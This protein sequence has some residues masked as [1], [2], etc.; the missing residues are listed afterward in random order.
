MKS[1]Q[2]TARKVSTVKEPGYYG[3]GGGLYL[4]VSQY[5]TKSWV[6]RFTLDRKTRD[7]GLGSI[8]TF[9]LKEARERARKYRQLLA[10]G[11]DPIEDRLKKRDEARADASERMLFKDAAQLFLDVHTQ[12][13]RNEKHRQQWRNTLRTYAYPT[14]GSRPVSAIDGAAI[15]EA[16]SPIWL[17]KQET[18]SRTKQRIERVVQWVRDGKPLPHQSAAK[19]VRHHPALPFTEL[20]AFMAELREN[21]SISARA[22]EFTILTAART[23]ETI[24]AKW[25]E[26]DLDA[27][28]WTVPGERMK[29]GKEHE[30]PLSKEAVTLLENLP[31]EK[32]GYMF[33]GARAKKP[34][35]NMAML[36]LLRGIRSG[37]TVH[38]FRSTFRDWAGDRT[39][40]PREVIEHALAHQIKD[41][42]EASYRRS[43]AL[44]KRRKLM[45]AWSSYC[46]RPP[47]SGKVIPIRGAA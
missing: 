6:F 19:R 23:G 1:C 10:D 42:A 14:L 37:L 35:S 4:Q 41:K 21:E 24:G 46:E 8:D 18:A 27:A 36:Q 9:T 40:F 17:T 32:G 29:G 38:G 47:G 12:G 25:S 15:T 5:G 45:D 22:L 16:L 3:D 26:I 30:V 20:P 28:V 11:I 39:N 13:W 44:E 43:S 31:R 33:A 2:L 34:L 7:M